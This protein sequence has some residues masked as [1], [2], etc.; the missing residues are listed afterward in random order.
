MKKVF[1][2]IFIIL[3]ITLFVF[4]YNLIV[5]AD[6]I[7]DLQNQQSNNQKQIDEMEEKKEE[8][9]QEKSNTETQ[10]D[11]LNKQ[12]S[13]YENEIGEL[14]YKIDDLNTQIAE[15]EE[16]IN[17][18]QEDYDKQKELLETRLIATYEAGETSFLDVL[19][20]SNSLSE[21]ISNYYYISEITQ[22]DAQLMED[23]ENEKKEIEQAKVNLEN[24]KKELDN[25]KIQKEAK[26]VELQA[27]KSEKTK[28]VSQ[29]SQEEQEL[30]QQIDE[31]TRDNQQIL[32][33][34]RIAQEKYKKQLEELANKKPSGNNGGGS[35]TSGTS[36]K[37]GF[38][39]PVNSGTV[40]ANGYYSTGEFHGAIDY[41]VNVGT[42]IYAAADG[43]VL[44]TKSLTTSYGTYVVIQH[45]NGLQ[46]WY[47]H[48]TPGS[49]CVSPGQTVSQGQMIMKS[50]NSGNSQGP[51]LHFEVRRAPYTYSYSA[52]KYGDDCRVDPNLYF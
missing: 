24:N 6:E 13:S 15:T 52:T 22:N 43:V 21:L 2:K 1:V 36:N 29:L 17:Q 34:I 47:A 11:E 44:T 37:G 9:S 23:I 12:I 42:P 14:E 27:A 46:T 8:V 49:I 48:G 50:G 18:K 30:Q 39:R 19:L 51:H 20:C 38:I 41:G 7:T 25:S 33:D 16:K 45:A 31:L 4:Q 35:S 3:L 40:T 32:N 28:Y 26:A 5:Y 10:I